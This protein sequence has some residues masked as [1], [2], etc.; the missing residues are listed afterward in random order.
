[1]YRELANPTGAL[2]LLAEKVMQPFFMKL[3][4]LLRPHLPE[5]IGDDRLLLSIMSIIAMVIHF[6][7]SREAVS[8]LTGRTY[9][10][11]FKTRLVEHI[12]EFSLKGLGG[13]SIQE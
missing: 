3:R 11:A 1:M 12:T 2:D 13:M 9:D 6:N 4:N 5:A 10:A 7:F 8:R